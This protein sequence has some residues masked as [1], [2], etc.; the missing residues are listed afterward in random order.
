LISKN[1]DDKTIYSDALTSTTNNKTDCVICHL[2]DQSGTDRFESAVGTNNALNPFHLNTLTTLNTGLAKYLT[3]DGDVDNLEDQVA[4]SITTPYEMNLSKKEVEKRLKTDKKY[5]KLFEIAFGEIN[6][7]NTTYA[8]ATYLKTLTT[9]SKYDEFLEGD[10]EAMSKEAKKGLANFI[11]FGCNGCHAGIT[12]GGQ[13]IQKFPV[14]AYNSIMDVTN[15]FKDYGR[16]VGSFGFNDGIYHS[17]PFENKGGFMGKDN[18]QL[19][20]VPMLR[21]VTKT[22]PYFHNGSVAKLRDAVYLMAK[23]QLGMSLTTQQTDEIIAFLKSLEGNIVK[24]KIQDG[25]KL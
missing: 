3:W 19:F 15:S 13:S 4:L 6:F 12:V 17:F 16:E 10:D 5:I 18:E 7:R 2:S 11:N 20:R 14:R 21:N 1:Q 22:S 25:D 23:H 9:R 8:I 24:Y